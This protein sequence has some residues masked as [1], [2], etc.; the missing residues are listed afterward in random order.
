MNLNRDDIK[1]LLKVAIFIALFVV[2]I[3]FVFYLLP[4][5]IIAFLVMLI[6]DTYKRNNGFQRK[7]KD[8][9]IKEAEIIEEKRND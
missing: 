9:D 3:K 2:A 8:N 7:K 1:Y 5:I 4:V 6:Y